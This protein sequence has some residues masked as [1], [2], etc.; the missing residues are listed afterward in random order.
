MTP[1]LLSAEGLSGLVF[2]VFVAATFAGALIATHARQLV[3]SVAGLA[4][5]FIGVA[6]LYYFL[7]SPF[8][9]MMQILIYV[10]AVCVTIIFAVMLADPLEPQK[11]SGGGAIV[12]LLGAAACAALALTLVVLGVSTAWKQLDGPVGDGGVERI[13]QALLTTN[14]LSFELI[15]LVLLVAILGSL[16]L[17]RAG[18]SKS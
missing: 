8:V 16:V 10:G 6:G 17:S 2:L 11:P 18:R 9:A 4:L 5:C 14:S 7:G 3:R 12:R 13:G 15:S 1:S